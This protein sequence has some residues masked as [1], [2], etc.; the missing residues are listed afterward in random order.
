MKN[1]MDY[2]PKSLTAETLQQGKRELKGIEVATR[3]YGFGLANSRTSFKGITSNVLSDIELPKSF[4]LD[5][6]SK[7][8]A[9]GGTYKNSFCGLVGINDSTGC[10]PGVI[11]LAPWAHT[12]KRRPW[13]PGKYSDRGY[14]EYQYDSAKVAGAELSS[15][16]I[17]GKIFHGGDLPGHEQFAQFLRSNGI[18]PQMGFVGFSLLLTSRR[19]GISGT[20][21]SQNNPHFRK[22]NNIRMNREKSFHDFH[23]Q[24]KTEDKQQLQG[25][26]NLA[27]VTVGVNGVLPDEFRVALKK[28]LDDLLGTEY[29]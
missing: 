11:Y 3:D 14:S 18:N 16:F 23:N 6:D 17:G 19:E 9:L 1:M 28:A 22:W 26:P 8:S 21:H 12:E 15:Q 5:P 10:E 24:H 20:S 4:V 13:S 27:D 25:P 7:R 29:S 2:K